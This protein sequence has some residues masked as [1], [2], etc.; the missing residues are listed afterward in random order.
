MRHNSVVIETTHGLVHF[1]HLTMQVK[2]TAIE[3]SAKTQAVLIDYALTIPPTTILATFGRKSL[4]SILHHTREILK[5][6][7]LIGVI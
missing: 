3:L 2:C 1:P 5:I 7:T 6:E 4:F